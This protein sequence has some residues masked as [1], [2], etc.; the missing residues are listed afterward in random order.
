M[1]TYSIYFSPTGGTK[2]VANL[3]ATKLDVNMKEVDLSKRE[4]D[5]I[6]FLSDDVCVIAMPSFGG[7]APQIAMERLAK[8]KGNKSRT[9]LVATYGNR[10]FEDTL[11]EMYDGAVEA[12]FCSIGAIS[13]ICQHSIAPKVAQN[14]PDEQDIAQLGEFCDKLQ[15]K[16][17]SGAMDTPDLTGDRPYKIYGGIAMKP[18]ASDKC[19]KCGLCAKN[20]PVG[21]IPMDTPNQ[22]NNDICITCMRCVVNCPVKARSIGENAVMA[23]TEKLQKACPDRKENKLFV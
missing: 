15:N 14:R 21:A 7:R 13:S 2:K 12:G 22:T 8:L 18:M 11:V 1:S 23:V 5:N 19:V 16:I 17:A 6:D 3:I 10:E 20:C 9:I 4:V